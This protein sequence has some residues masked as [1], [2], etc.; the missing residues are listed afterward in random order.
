MG[1]TNNH[2]KE[3]NRKTYTKVWKPTTRQQH[4]SIYERIMQE[5]IFLWWNEPDTTSI[6][7]SKVISDYLRAKFT[8]IKYTDKLAFKTNRQ[9]QP[10][11][12]IVD[13]TN[14]ANKTNKNITFS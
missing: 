12:N 5:F 11:D 9:R 14:A 10:M 3:Y 13:V 7:K 8:I 6:K 1:S 2:I 4:P